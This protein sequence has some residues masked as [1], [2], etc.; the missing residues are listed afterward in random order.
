MHDEHNLKYDRRMVKGVITLQEYRI[1]ICDSDT[2]YV[3]G[4]MEYINMNNE[5]PL[6]VSAFSGVEAI[7]EYLEYNGLDLLLLEEGIEKKD[8]KVKVVGLSNVKKINED[9]ALIYKYQSTYKIAE[10]I[11]HLLNEDNQNI[12]M[13]SYVYGIYSPIGRSGKTSLARG[14]CNYY[15][16]SFYIGFEEYSGCFN[17]TY[18]SS[19]YKEIY[20]RF[21]Y[22]LISENLLITETIE[23][24][25]EETGLKAFIALDYMDLKQLER[26][27]I[28]WLAEVLREAESYKRIVFD[29]G[30]G[31]MSDIDIMSDMDKVYV[32]VLND[33]NSINKLGMFKA[34][35][36]DKKNVLLEQK[37]NYVEVPGTE[38]DSKIMREFIIRSGM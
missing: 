10:I 24:L 11:T 12:K 3:V 22:Y 9:N 35:L 30:I 7:T 20:E 26:K 21:M 34:L 19:R 5:I 27:H 36:A 6:R 8:F 33:K 14:I 31:A 4:F 18:A 23:E 1:G 25:Y 29:I 17:K 16:E 13:S 2:G 37:I 32:T 15:S 38:Y 28:K